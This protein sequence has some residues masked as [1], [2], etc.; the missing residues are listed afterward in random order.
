MAGVL[1]TINQGVIVNDDCSHILF[2]N[3]LF[4]K[5]IGIPEEELI[6]RKILDLYPPERGDIA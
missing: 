1:E 5:M 3:R 4:L 2:A 6:G